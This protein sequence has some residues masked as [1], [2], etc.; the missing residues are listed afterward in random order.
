VP[1][2]VFINGLPATDPDNIKKAI[3]ATSKILT[4]PPSGNEKSLSIIK[5]FIK[6]DKDF[7]CP[8]GGFKTGEL[9]R[10]FVDKGLAFLFTGQQ[11]TVLNDLGKKIGPAKSQGLAQFN[12][13][14]TFEANALATNYFQKI[15]TFLAAPRL[16]IKESVNAQT[17]MYEGE[18]LELNIHATSKG[19]MGKAGFKLDIDDISFSKTSAALQTVQAPPAK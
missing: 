14:K 13:T 19:Q 12:T 1:L 9:I 7:S 2:K 10:N 11:A 16:R 8:M 5:K 18:P 17:R 15:E 4:T 3:V 6:H